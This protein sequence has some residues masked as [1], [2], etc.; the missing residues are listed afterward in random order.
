MAS[1]LLEYG[2]RP[3]LLIRSN[4]EICD[5][6]LRY[7][8]A[9]KLEWSE[10]PVIICDDWT[11]AQIKAYRI[12]SRKSAQWAD[13]DDELLKLELDDLSE[14]DF[15]MDNLGFTV[16]EMSEMLDSDSGQSNAD[17]GNDEKYNAT[18]DELDDLVNAYG[19]KLN[20]TWLLGKH[21][22][23]CGDSSNEEQISKLTEGAT[24]DC[25][26]FDPPWDADLAFKKPTI[27][28]QVKNILS[29]TDGQRAFDAVTLFG[30]PTWLFGWDC[31]TSWYA[32]NRPLKR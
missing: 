19:I 2:C 18:D 15:D 22:L 32:P 29:F 31:V 4:G 8:A 5:G 14:M 28:S 12:S 26:V 13:F 30:A 27:A 9:L 21:K 17:G 16:D 1:M 25:L 11:D 10:L 20:Q 6:H 7:L 23:L 24:I 3:P